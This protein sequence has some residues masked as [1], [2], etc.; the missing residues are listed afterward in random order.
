MARNLGDPIFAFANLIPRVKISGSYPLRIDAKLAK[1]AASSS[2][3]I[4]KVEFFW[5][6]TNGGA[7]TSLGST[8]S[9]TLATFSDFA[10]ARCPTK[11]PYFEVLVDTASAPFVSGTGNYIY[12]EIT[13]G[14]GATVFKTPYVQVDVV[15]S[16]LGSVYVSPSGNDTTGDGSLG[17]PYKTVQKGFS[18]VADG[19]EVL[20]AD[21]D[22]NETVAISRSNT[23]MITV[24]PD[25]SNGAT[26]HG[27]RLLVDAAAW[28]WQADYF[29][30]EDVKV[31]LQTTASWPPAIYLYNTQSC[32]FIGCQVYQNTANDTTQVAYI[33]YSKETYGAQTPAIWIEG[34]NIYHTSRIFARGSFTIFRGNYVH[35][36]YGS[37]ISGLAG[38]E[39]GTIFEANYITDVDGT[40][41]TVAGGDSGLEFLSKDASSYSPP[42]YQQPDNFTVRYNRFY[43]CDEGILVK[44]ATRGLSVYCNEVMVDENFTSDY[45][46]VFDA[47]GN[48]G[49]TKDGVYEDWFVA[50]NTVVAKQV[51]NT[52][53]GR[54]GFEMF[55][56]AGAEKYTG[57]GGDIRNIVFANNILGYNTSLYQDAIDKVFGGGSYSALPGCV[58]RNNGFQKSDGRSF[59]GETVSTAFILGDDWSD[60]WND[61]TRDL[62]LLSDSAFASAGSPIIGVGY[63]INGIPIPT[64]GPIPLGAV[65]TTKQVPSIEFTS[66]PDVTG[67][68]GVAYSFTTNAIGGGGSLTY[69]M[70]TGPSGATF[71]PATK[72]FSWTPSAGDDQKAHTVKLSATDGTE[73]AYQEW[74]IYVGIQGPIFFEKTS[75]A[76][77]VLGVKVY[78]DTSNTNATVWAPGDA[79]FEYPGGWVTPG[80]YVMEVQASKIHDNTSHAL[81]AVARS[82]W[83]IRARKYSFDLKYKHWLVRG[84]GFQ[85][86]A[87]RPMLFQNGSPVQ[88]KITLRAGDT[89]QLSY[90]QYNDGSYSYEAESDGQMIYCVDA[91]I[92]RG[93]NWGK[94]YL[95]YDT[96]MWAKFKANC[97]TAYGLYAADLTTSGYGPTPLGTLSTEF[98]T[99]ITDA[100]PFQAEK[101]AK[102]L[103]NRAADYIQNPSSMQDSLANHK[104]LLE[105]A[106][107]NIQHT[108]QFDQYSPAHFNAGYG[109]RW[110]PAY[111]VRHFEDIIAA[112]AVFGYDPSYEPLQKVLT[113]LAQRVKASAYLDHNWTR[114]NTQVEG[115]IALHKDDDLYTKW[116]Y[117]TQG[118]TTFGPKGGHNWIEMAPGFWARKLL[119]FDLSDSFYQDGLYYVGWGANQDREGCDFDENGLGA[120]WNEFYAHNEIQG[121]HFLWLTGAF[122]DALV[123]RY[124]RRHYLYKIDTTDSAS[125][126]FT[127]INNDI[128]AAFAQQRFLEEPRPVSISGSE[129]TWTITFPAVS[130]A[131]SYDLLWQSAE[132]QPL[133]SI[134]TGITA[135]PYTLNLSD[136]G[137]RGSGVLRLVAKATNKESCVSDGMAIT[138]TAGGGSGSHRRRMSGCFG[139]F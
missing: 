51:E 63:D 16:S 103:R 93:G 14:T 85:D 3:W 92:Q 50:H 91:P 39:L 117:Y 127:T 40:F 4:T 110:Y 69:A 45:A 28:N 55:G 113:M 17:N 106:L 68:V 129:P 124:A 86:K 136:L 122:E 11:V 42:P 71:D 53:C 74:E 46:M 44:Q 107:Q 22:Y 72:T 97:E 137:G 20:L 78:P 37:L 60:V 101:C 23:R 82:G 125:I 126:S 111:T 118:A 95:S 73:T 81:T 5:S 105:F 12:A 133:E 8:T 47:P 38:S 70:V 65:S 67:S 59:S 35:E 58:Q 52:F 135:S 61:E 62:T 131:S 56:S 116:I 100:D 109:T 21:G 6:A 29:S 123:T 121:A 114:G 54:F 19:G 87:L 98:A 88:Q 134:V 48:P 49:G 112:A 41:G 80:D 31:Q 30:F 96:A 138:A 90:G 26:K 83:G 7:G 104:K 57:S 43:E 10:H 89:L 102:Y 94:G 66:R 76:L 15:N 132:G 99:A 79:S 84:D 139:M 33:F 1:D 25:Y 119:G 130:G 77:D 115:G 75:K 2:E 27:P 120:G 128:F 108:Y 13:F 24:K 9:L 18:V 32:R 36:Y 64:S 34:C